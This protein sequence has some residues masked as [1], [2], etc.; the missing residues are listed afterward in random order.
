MRRRLFLGLLVV[1]SVLAVA[2]AAVVFRDELTNGWIRV[3]LEDMADAWLVPEVD[4]GGFSLPD[5]STVRLS[6][7]SLADGKGRPLLDIDELVVSLAEIPQE[8][9][10]LRLARLH[11]EHPVIHLRP[12]PEQPGFVPAGWLPLL[13]SELKEAPEELERAVRPSEVLDLREVQIVG[14]EL[15]LEDR[16]GAVQRLDG[17]DLSLV[18]DP[19]TTPDG[20][21]GH[22]L[23]LTL[24]QPPGL[25][26]EAGGHVDLDGARAWLDTL[27]LD[28]DLGDTAAVAGLSPGLRRVVEEHE[29]R[30]RVHVEGSGRLELADLL[31]SELA[32]S[33]RLDAVHGA[34]G[35]W[36]LPVD[37]AQLDLALSERT[38]QLRGA[39]A[40]LLSGEVELSQADLALDEQGL[41]AAADWRIEGLALHELIRSEDHRDA[42]HHSVLDGSGRVF[43]AQYDASLALVVDQLRLGAP[44][45]PPVLALDATT[46][47][48]LRPSTD[49][50]PLAADAL[51]VGRLDVNLTGPSGRPHGLPLP[52]VAD[53][54]AEAEGIHWSHWFVVDWVELGSGSVTLAL[55]GDPP[56]SLSGVQG[57]LQGLGG[58][59]TTSLNAS[60]RLAPGTGGGGATAEARGALDLEAPALYFSEWGFSADAAD[61]RAAALLPVGVRGVVQELLPTGAVRGAGT[62][63]FPL[64][65]GEPAL[66]LE[67][68]V[69][70]ATL[71]VPGLR[72]PVGR[73]QARLDLSEGV[74]TVSEGALT[75]AGGTLRIPQARYSAGAGLL[76]ETEAEGL[77][78]DQL[79]TT[80]G[81][82]LGSGRLYGTAMIGARFT[83]R[84]GATVLGGLSLS[85]A[86]L[87]VES[88]PGEALAWPVVEA[89]LEPDGDHLRFRG[90]LRGGEGG[91][92]AA[93][94]MAVG[95]DR[96]VITELDGTLDL[97]VGAQR[98][99]L[100]P[101]LQLALA[102]TTGGR[103][104]VDEA[105][106]VLD[107]NDPVGRSTARLTLAL[108]SGSWRF[109]GYRL[110]RLQGRLPLSFGDRSLVIENG[111]LQGLGGKL[112]LRRARWSLD[113]DEGE[114]Q[115][116]LRGLQ[117]GEML[118]VDGSPQGIA[119][120]TH[121][122]GTVAVALE[123]RALAVTGGKG[124]VHV[125]E[126]RLLSVPALSAMRRREGGETASS[127]HEL[128]LRYRLGPRALVFPELQVDLGAVRYRGSGEVRWT[129]GVDLRLEGGARPGERATAADLAARLVAWHVRGTL[130]EPEVQALP[131]GIDTRTF[132]QRAAA[133]AR[134][135]E[136]RPTT[137]VLDSDHGG[138][139]DELPE[140]EGGHLAPVELGDPSDLD[141]PEDDW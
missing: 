27:R 71:A 119:G 11:L 61:D 64:G 69:D 23:Q 106:G 65:P 114:L 139:L 97:D 118:P 123:E 15:R 20:T 124:E 113:H 63:R 43:L 46:L 94:T 121:G 70:G 39:R 30:G 73:G 130:A 12:D 88:G 56:W 52:A 137:G 102:D 68:E 57:V 78:L 134:D 33:A 26:L 48:N 5:P 54:R 115:W 127:G 135:P 32:L 93:G 6:D 116:A 126:G 89:S 14:G 125:R 107:L 24:G 105:E 44:G 18:A 42:D 81:A 19:T 49:G 86:S 28:V 41:A 108:E 59:E 22:A 47:R 60:L 31:E 95:G 55:D 17:I 136:A 34:A 85:P 138:A 25:V 103:L 4:I 128:D 82:T 45:A 112:E 1:A 9:Q 62:A 35:L 140:V 50:A 133:D 92:T 51:S 131:L 96:L 8:G 79:R 129:G 2:A 58:G 87:R 67:L 111:L 37:E 53:V 16:Q 66:G 13:E 83:E 29:L 40:A 77:R 98:R 122:E 84:S 80:A 3:A 141:G 110:A 21:A 75:T 117:L 100:P 90:A 91:L 74:V 76:L 120:R 72:L 7:V 38:V 132:E 36:R 10:P 109:G 99:L 101:S 104:V